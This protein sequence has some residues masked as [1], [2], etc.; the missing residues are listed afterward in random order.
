M[1]DSASI[2]RN[3]KRD[4]VSFVAG[5]RCK[6]SMYK[7]DERDALAQNAVF[8]RFNANKSLA[9]PYRSFLIIRAEW[10]GGIL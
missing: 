9:L 1:A 5:I 2:D 6:T 3:E 10:I 8:T 7:S 4:T